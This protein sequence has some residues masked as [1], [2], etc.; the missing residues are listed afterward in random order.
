[1]WSEERIP[2]LSPNG[3]TEVKQPIRKLR[4]HGKTPDEISK[5]LLRLSN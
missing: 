5:A 4:K 2:K 1:M 3:K